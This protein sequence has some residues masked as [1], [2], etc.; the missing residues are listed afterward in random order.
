MHDQTDFYNSKEE[1]SIRW[2]DQDISIDWPIGS[3][4]KI[5]SKDEAGTLLKDADLPD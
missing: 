1:K 5:S 4:L 3:V 2:D